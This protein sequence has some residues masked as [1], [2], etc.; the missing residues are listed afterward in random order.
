MRHMALHGCIHNCTWVALSVDLQHLHRRNGQ[1]SRAENIQHLTGRYHIARG[2]EQHGGHTKIRTGIHFRKHDNNKK[3]E[4]KY[5]IPKVSSSDRC[6]LFLTPTIAILPLSS[7]RETTNSYAEGICMHDRTD[8]QTCKAHV[9]ED[10]YG[11]HV[12]RTDEQTNN[13][14]RMARTLSNNEQARNR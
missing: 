8:Q 4:L 13:I 11:K 5:R 10:D 14:L 9:S 3:I 7:H 12:R 2:D 1:T 6:E